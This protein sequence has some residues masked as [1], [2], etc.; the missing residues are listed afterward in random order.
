MTETRFEQIDRFIHAADSAKAP[1]RGSEDYD[2]VRE[3][4]RLACTAWARAYDPGA[5]V[6]VDETLLM[7]K[8]RVLFKV[9]IRMKRA[10]VGIKLY[11]LTGDTTL[12][13]VW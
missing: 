8:G 9:R 7:F 12:Q 5:Y 11:V 2:K 1:K 10:K 3:L 4:I 13:V 6:C